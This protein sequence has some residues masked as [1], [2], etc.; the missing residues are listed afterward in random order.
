LWLWA[1]LDSAVLEE[2][3]VDV[4]K[5]GWEVLECVWNVKAGTFMALFFATAVSM[6][7]LAEAPA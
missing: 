1:R 6:S 5:G 7:E 4:G 3:L 2:F